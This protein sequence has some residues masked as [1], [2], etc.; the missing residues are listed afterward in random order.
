MSWWQITVACEKP[1]LEALEQWLLEAGAAS[2]TLS[3]ARDDPILEPLPGQMP[4]WQ[5]LL[6]TGLFDES[7]Q[8]EKLLQELQEALGIKAEHSALESLPDKQWERAWM[9]N[10]HAMPLGESL[11][12]IPS[13]E[14]VVDPAAINIFMD[15]GLAFGSGTHPTTALCLRWLDQ[16]RPQGLEVIDYGCG[17]GIL[18]I[19]AWLGGA[20]RLAAVDLDPQALQATRANLLRNQLDPAQTGIYLPEQLPDLQV[21][22]IL[23]N[24]L[25]GPLC[26]LRET[27]LAHMKP[28]AQLLLSGMLSTQ[29][30]EIRSHY[31]GF[32]EFTHEQ[33][34]GDWACL[35]GFRLDPAA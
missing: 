5:H 25:S 31:Q 28:Q 11:W 9:E 4:L 33:H 21:D 30:A 22:L 6:V 15:P 2:I 13:H 12:V 10:Y 32:I 19:A 35:A 34:D 26:E 1:Q 18:A 29:V 8:A 14:A 7:Q 23:A 20:R 17:S 3:D 24:I 27:F 16:H